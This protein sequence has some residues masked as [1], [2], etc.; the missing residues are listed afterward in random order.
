MCYHIAFL[1]AEY[2]RL[3]WA[4]NPLAWLPPSCT[5]T[6]LLTSEIIYWRTVWRRMVLCPLTPQ[7][8]SLLTFEEFRGPVCFPPL[9]ISVATVETLTGKE[10][11]SFFSRAQPAKPAG[12]QTTL[13]L[14]GKPVRGGQEVEETHF[15]L[16]DR[17]IAQPPYFINR[18]PEALGNPS[19]F[20]LQSRHV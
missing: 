17:G 6:L 16:G 11:P 10:S 18:E 14:L 5:P 8:S 9:F 2:S 19:S 13:A 3:A 4:L 1:M 7:A 15:L 20:C 12:S